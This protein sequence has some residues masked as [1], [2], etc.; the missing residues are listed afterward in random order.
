MKLKKEKGNKNE[1]KWYKLKHEKENIKIYESKY[2][3]WVFFKRVIM[4]FLLFLS[5]YMRKLILSILVEC[6]VID[7]CID[8]W[9]LK[10]WIN[11]INVWIYE[12]ESF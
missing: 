2:E 5:G 7:F 11:T 8:Y 6:Q 3:I 4:K 9:P 1:I 10:K 12:L